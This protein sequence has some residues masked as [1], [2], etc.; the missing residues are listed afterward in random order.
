MDAARLDSKGPGANFITTF[1]TQHMPVIRSGISALGMIASDPAARIRDS[2]KFTIS[3]HGYM[4]YQ[5]TSTWSYGIR[6]GAQIP[7][8]KA[9]IDSGSIT[10]MHAVPI[11]GI[12]IE[13]AV[14]AYVDYSAINAT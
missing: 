12:G 5:L 11:S 1:G 7:S 8:A 4:V 14:S 2:A 13:D 3:K 6:R 9:W 10:I